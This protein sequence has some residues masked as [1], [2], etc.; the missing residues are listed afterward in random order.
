MLPV[1]GLFLFAVLVCIGALVTI[2][3]LFLPASTVSGILAGT[4]R[5][6]LWLMGLGCIALV[7]LV[8]YVAM[9]AP[10]A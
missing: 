8:I 3:R 4:A 2:G 10:G 1:A 6:M 9:G 7:V 5:A